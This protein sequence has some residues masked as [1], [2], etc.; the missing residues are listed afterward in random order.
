MKK[1]P[2]LLYSF[3]GIVPT[4]QGPIHIGVQDE[5]RFMRMEQAVSKIENCIKLNNP[6]C[7]RYAKQEGAIRDWKGYAQFDTIA[8]GRLAL[9]RWWLRR[10]CTPAACA[11]YK[12]NQPD[13]T[14]YIRRVLLLAG[15]EA[16]LP[17]D[18]ACPATE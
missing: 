16:G 5:T 2:I 7:I 17:L 11:L 4:A 6:G 18:L 9:H 8:N 10:R 13:G 12:Y 3:I 15:L 1:L 14:A